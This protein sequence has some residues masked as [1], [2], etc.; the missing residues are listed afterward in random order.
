MNIL[1]KN[2]L[3]IILW[4]LDSKIEGILH[5]NNINEEDLLTQKKLYE[6]LNT[7]YLKIHDMWK[8]NDLEDL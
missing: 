4:A 2:E 1:T 8:S 7:V 3:A 5:E 6:Q